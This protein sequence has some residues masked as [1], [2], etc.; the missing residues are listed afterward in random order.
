MEPIFFETPEAFRAWLAEYHATV[1]ELWVG[2]RKKETGLPSIT[3][4]QAVDE[5]LCA[6]WIDGIRKSLDADSYVIRFTPRRPGSTWSVVNLKRVPELER[7]GR[8]LPAGLEAFAR[9]RDDRAAIYS[10][11]QR[12]TASLPAEYELRFRENEKAWTY[13]ESCPPGYRR[14]AAHW[15][16]SARK[17]ET[18]LRRLA[19]LIDESSHE[20]RITELRRPGKDSS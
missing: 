10:Y 8:M 20:R 4:P 9:R 5:A 7:E 6:G 17:E 2:F 13:Y 19:T 14:L 18:R 15:V 12:R 1:G 3:W 16:I 11:E